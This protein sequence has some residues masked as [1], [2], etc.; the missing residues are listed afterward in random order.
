MT[1]LI[2]LPAPCGIDCFITCDRDGYFKRSEG[3]GA[4]L[5][6]MRMTRGARLSMPALSAYMTDLTHAETS[7]HDA[8]DAAETL[9]GVKGSHPDKI[10]TRAA[11]CASSA[12]VFRLLAW[13]VTMRPTDPVN[14]GIQARLILSVSGPLGCIKR[15]EY[16][17]LMAGAKALTIPP[18]EA[19]QAA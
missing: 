12:K 3:Q 13:I 6:A 5:D 7:A 14:I 9:H 1:D 19:Q 15:D 2:R 8:Y 17:A 10:A 18:P 11:L 16:E 4:H